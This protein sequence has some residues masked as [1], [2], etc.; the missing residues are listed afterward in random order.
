V[1]ENSVKKPTLI[2]LA[3]ALAVHVEPMMYA[4]TKPE[5]PVFHPGKDGVGYPNC[6]YCPEPQYSQ[7]ARDAKFQGI[8]VLQVIIQ[9]DGHGTNIQVVKKAGLGLDERALEAVRSWTFKPALG[10][11]GKP[12]ATVTD[13]EVNFRL[14]DNVPTKPT[15]AP[16]VHAGPKEVT[17][18]AGR[19]FER[20]NGY[21]ISVYINVAILDGNKFVSPENAMK[22]QAAQKWTIRCSNCNGLNS[23]TYHG[24]VDG[25]K[26]ELLT[27]DLKGKEHRAKF[28]LFAHDWIDPLQLPQ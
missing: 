18:V 4:Q 26:L 2:M 21:G 16:R 3:A 15:Q 5:Q 14:L 9:P 19:W 10:P 17:V 27:V 23:G 11:D 20:S 7:E 24:T 8:V 1:E 28:K 22:N 13:I 6:L 12:V 25:D